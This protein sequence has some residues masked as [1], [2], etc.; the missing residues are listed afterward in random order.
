MGATPR[1]LLRIRPTQLRLWSFAM[2]N[3]NGAGLMLVPIYL[4][5]CRVSDLGN[6]HET[7]RSPTNA[8]LGL[9]VLVAAVHSLAVIAAGAFLARLVYRSLGLMFV[10]R[11]CF[12]LDAIWAMNLNFAGAQSLALIL[13]SRLWRFA[14][15]CSAHELQSTAPLCIPAIPAL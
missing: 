7:A 9:A 4:G 3:A 14:R 12:N 5:L 1:V 15:P 13:T 10:S 11:G 6:D 2:A 8:N